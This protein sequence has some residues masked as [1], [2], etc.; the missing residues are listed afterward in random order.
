MLLSGVMWMVCPCAADR[1]PM[2]GMCT[3]RY[4]SRVYVIH[5]FNY[6]EASKVR[7]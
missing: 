6:L 4:A 3:C 1:A 2:C 5:R 7:P